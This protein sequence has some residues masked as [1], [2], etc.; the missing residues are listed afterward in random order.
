MYSAYFN[1]QHGVIF[2]KMGF[3]NKI[4]YSQFKNEAKRSIVCLNSMLSSPSV[5]QVP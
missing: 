1:G 4:I 5:S 2:Q 3:F